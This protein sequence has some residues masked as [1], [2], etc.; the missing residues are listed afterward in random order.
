VRGDFYGSSCCAPL[1]RRALLG[2][3]VATVASLAVGPQPATAG[4][5]EDAKAIV[6]A[7][8]AR[9]E[10]PWLVSH[11]IR[12]LGADFRLA[13]GR[14]AVDFLLGEVLD[15]QVVNG[16]SYLAFPPK[17]EVHP[18]MFLK[19]LLEAGVPLTYRFTRKGKA[20]TLR[21]VADHARALFRFSEQTNPNT[22]AWS[23]IA[24]TRTTPPARGTWRNAWGEEVRLAAV[25]QAGL[26]ALEA[27]SRPIQEARDRNA[28]L[29]RQ[30]P[31]HGFT[32]G[33]T[34]LLYSLLAALQAGYGKE[35]RQRLRDQMD[36]LIYRLHADP[37]LAGRFYQAQATKVPGT[38][39][40]LLDTNLKFLGHA[41]E[42]LNF[43]RRHRLYEVPT[44]LQSKVTD[45][46][47]LLTA[48]V[49]R[50]RTLELTPV[51]TNN[52]VLYQQ[53]VGDVCHA[54]HSLRLA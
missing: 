48:G 24:L 20:W 39:W 18:N 15:E 21:D 19:T 42:C 27:A 23:L 8:A 38:A 6:L 43:A 9:P 30:A 34:H 47:A 37:D 46:L 3:A 5:A 51:R 40:Y 7:E 16:R 22:I 49:A 25:A 45:G 50:L 54:Y 31:I 13:P 14:S 33:G 11:G 10:D 41:L 44:D 53:L 12:A 17:I 35:T 28:R 29:D 4:L 36:L 2:G 1:G 52:P 32:C 26:A